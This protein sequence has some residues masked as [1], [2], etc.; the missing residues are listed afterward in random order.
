MYI[1]K[2]L[3]EVSANYS[4]RKPHLCEL[5]KIMFLKKQKHC[6]FFHSTDLPLISILRMCGSF[7]KDFHKPS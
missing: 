1:N 5:S 4:V 3:E 2:R 7:V 6:T